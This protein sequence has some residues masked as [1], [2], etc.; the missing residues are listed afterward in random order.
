LTSCG[1]QVSEIEARKRYHVAS[2]N[3]FITNIC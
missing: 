2:D 3:D 1:I